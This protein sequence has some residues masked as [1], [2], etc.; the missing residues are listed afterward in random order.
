M[1]HLVRQDLD[2]THG[3]VYML[4]CQLRR[5]DAERNAVNADFAGISKASYREPDRNVGVRFGLESCIDRVEPIANGLERNGCGRRR[6]GLR[7][8]S[9]RSGHPFGVDCEVVPHKHIKNN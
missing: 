8:T 2:P 1:A 5:S 4:V 9:V 3:L 6:K 7:C